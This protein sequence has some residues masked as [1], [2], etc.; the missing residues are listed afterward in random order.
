MEP[1]RKLL[2]EHVWMCPDAFSHFTLAL[3]KD[4]DPSQGHT[5]GLNCKNFNMW[6]ICVPDHHSS[7]GLSGTF[8]NVMDLVVK[9]F[10]PLHAI[11]N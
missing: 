1:I 2:L 5:A 6:W 10:Q 11:L 8:S 3:E 9:E 4:N 7:S